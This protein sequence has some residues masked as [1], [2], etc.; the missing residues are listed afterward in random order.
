MR[1]LIAGI[2]G[3][4]LAV[5]LSQ[6]P[7]Y[8]QQYTQRLGGAVDELRVIT[9]DFDRAAIA[10]GLDRNQALERFGAA[11]DG[12]LAERGTAM[13]TTFTRYE[14]LSATLERIE[15]ADPV[16]RFQALPAY[17]DSDI[18][19]RTLENYE[20][21]VPVTIEGVLYAGGG[22]IVGYLVLSGLW[23]FATMPFRRRRPVYRIER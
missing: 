20:P 14:Q 6:F 9:E 16:T 7:E 23:R 2:G 4:G 3:V 10:G 1:R 8:A 21:A 15:N 12:F 17:L 13:T 5:T 18:G 22:F 11:D 19:R